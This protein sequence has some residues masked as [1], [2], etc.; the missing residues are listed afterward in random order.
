MDQ[1]SEMNSEMNTI[2]LEG[3]NPEISFQINLDDKKKKTL[4]QST[5]IKDLGENVLTL[6]QC[7]ICLSP[8][9]N[10]LSCPK[11]NNF[12]CEKCF[13]NYFKKEII[14][15]CPICK[16]KILKTDLKP[17][18]IIKDIEKIIYKKADKENKIEE[19]TKLFEEKKLLWEDEDVYM[20]DLL[21]KLL[22]FQE[23]IKVY[24]K[25]YLSYIEKW[26]SRIQRLFELYEDK[27]M[28]LIGDIQFYIDRYKPK[29]KKNQNSI[30]K[31]NNKDDKL[32][33]LVN[34]ILSME[35]AHFNELNNEKTNFY[36]ILPIN[37]VNEINNFL[38]KPM[39]IIPNISN[40]NIISIDLEKKNFNKKTIRR[41]EYNIH[42]G[43][44]EIK[45]K[46][47]YDNLYNSL[48]Q[49]NFEHKSNWIYMLTLKKTLD[50]KYSMLIPMK[51]VDNKNNFTYEAEV[52]F[53]E[54]R[55]DEVHKIKI[56]FKIQIFNIANN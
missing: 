55:N 40:Y 15:V 21:N 37:V 42:I 52:N 46:F 3:W 38:Y 36:E 34:K 28:K 11:C 29:E 41:K 5:V 17:S 50:D 31:E 53:N 32:N 16:Q 19:L 23:N 30:E 26:K 35:R 47:K 13:Q 1:F 56:D 22:N 4:S 45:F 7:F 25:E 8:A 2:Q 24:K 18:K 27:I 10:P 9:I 54:L 43:D 49:F 48:C 44:Y 39:I 51:L 20:N 12:A 14:K 33:M 6:T